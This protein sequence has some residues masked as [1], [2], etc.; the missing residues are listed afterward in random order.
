MT[1]AARATTHDHTTQVRGRLA[2]ALVALLCLAMLLPP[3]T[4]RAAGERIAPGVK[5]VTDGAQ[6]TANFVFTD[7]TGAR[8]IG[9][10]AHCASAT[11]GTGTDGCRERSLPL[12]TEV[13]IENASEPGRLAYSSWATMH[14]V[15]ER[16]RNACLYND[17][18]L[19]RIHPADHGRVDPT[20]P[21]F[22]GPTGLAPYSHPGKEVYSYG[23]SDLRPGGS[24][25]A[26]RGRSSGTSNDNWAITVS[27]F[28][29]GVPGDSGS[30]FLDHRGR[31]VGVL[32]SLAIYPRTGSNTLV[33]LAKAL[34]YVERHTSL[35]VRLRDGWEPF[36]P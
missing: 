11:G 10:A 35:R 16:D 25:D 22:G 30:G 17:F 32:S 21:V 9:M 27:T 6:C 20:M 24:L 5:V 1:R 8:F 36:A 7:A 34:E 2:T 14:R 19:V 15:G 33:N 3:T 4:A 26:K 29:P 23:N 31:A 18:A 28:T 12:G 13:D